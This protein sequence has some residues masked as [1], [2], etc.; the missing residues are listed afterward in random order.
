[1]ISVVVADTKRAFYF[2]C[3]DRAGHYFFAPGWNNLWDAREIPGFPWTMGNIDGGLLKNGKHPDVYDGKVYWTCGG[4]PLW[5]A[6]VWWDNSVDRRGASN[7]GF[8]VQG[9]DHTQAPEAF[10]YACSLFPDVV[11]R[12]RQALVLVERTAA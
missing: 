9:F 2:G 4:S 10:A 8:Y 3:H 6:Y 1:M 12:Q 7:S 5:L 11:T